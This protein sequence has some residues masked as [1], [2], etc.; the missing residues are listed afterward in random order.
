MSSERI[1]E[2]LLIRDKVFSFA[3]CK[4]RANYP[5]EATA[6]GDLGLAAGDTVC[7]TS[8]DG[9]WWTG[10]LSTDPNSTSGIFPSNF[11]EV[12]QVLNLICTYFHS[13]SHTPVYY[14]PLKRREA[15][16]KRRVVGKNFIQ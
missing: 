9:D 1:G 10:F 2:W 4:V 8:K 14:W 13:D 15:S 5:F 3:V 16:N 6:E 11:V 7:V 12:I